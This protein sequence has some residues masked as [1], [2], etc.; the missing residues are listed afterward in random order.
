MTAR[1]KARTLLYREE[2]KP[3][4]AGYCQARLAYQ[5]TYCARPTHNGHPMCKA[6]RYTRRRP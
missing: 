6:H 4:P 3:P 5:G 1:L 2:R